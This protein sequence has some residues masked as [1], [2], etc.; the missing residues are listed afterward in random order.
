MRATFAVLILAVL[1]VSS[2]RPALGGTIDGRVLLVELPA[3]DYTLYYVERSVFTVRLKGAT[4]SIE[5]R[6][7]YIGDGEIAIPLVA[8]ASK[9][10]FLQGEPYE[11][12]DKFEKGA[13]IRVRP[14]YVKAVDL[15]PGDVYVTM[16]GLTFNLPSE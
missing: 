3:E 2:S 14:G 9:G 1:A 13:T 12:G 6:E 4:A 5:G 15:K 7:M 16:R 11:Q 8:H 10:I